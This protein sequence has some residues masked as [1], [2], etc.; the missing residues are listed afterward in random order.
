MLFYD[1]LV[2]MDLPLIQLMPAPMP[3]IAFNGEL[4]KVEGEITLPVMARTRS[5]QSIVF[6]TFTVVWVPSAYNAILEH[7]G[8]NQLDTV[9]STKHLLVRF[10]TVLGIDEICGNQQLA[11]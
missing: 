4:V 8:M 10:P 1:I 6:M 9:V 5:Q 2:P 7:P 3:L 11:R